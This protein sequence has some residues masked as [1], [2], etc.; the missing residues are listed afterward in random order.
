M[1]TVSLFFQTE[2]PEKEG[3]LLKLYWSCDIAGHVDIIQSRF[4]RQSLC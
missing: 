2:L 3:V 1:E 4:F